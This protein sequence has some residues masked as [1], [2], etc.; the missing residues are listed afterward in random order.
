MRQGGDRPPRSLAA[1]RQVVCTAK[2]RDAYGR[3]VASCAVDG[4][5]VAEEIVAAGLAWAFAEYST[6]YVETEAVAKEANRGVW[7]APA[8]PPW[9]YRADRWSRAAA[10]APEGCPIKGNIARDGE[11]I[12]HTPWFPWYDRTQIS[13]AKG[14]RWFCDEGTAQALGW[15]AAEE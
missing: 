4:R 11:R 1:E 3:I 2:D 9:A 5:D 13:E 8:Q 14:K 7:Q 10:A 6:D 12:Y 15:R